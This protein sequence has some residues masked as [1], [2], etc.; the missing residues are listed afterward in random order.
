M[1]QMK[2]PGESDRMPYIQPRPRRSVPS[3]PEKSLDALY[4]R[5]L[6]AKRNGALYGAFPYPTKISPEAIALYIAAHTKPGDTVFDGFGGSGTTGLAA[7][8]C[9]RP[10]DE[11]RAEAVRLGLN[12]QWGAP[13]MPYCTNWARSA[14]LW[15]GH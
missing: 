9:E 10:T 5:P 4:R 8:L 3:M 13:A 6:A 1:T 7:L 2:M 15:G 12:V 11:L 14:R